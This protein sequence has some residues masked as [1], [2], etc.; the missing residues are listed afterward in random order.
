[1]ATVTADTR[2]TNSALRVDPRWPESV[3]SRSKSVAGLLLAVALV[4]ALAG[5]GGSSSAAGQSSAQTAS[6]ASSG[7]CADVTALKA[8]LAALTQVRPLKDGVPALQSAIGNVKTSLD[9]AAASASSTLQP[10]V[11]QVKSAFAAVQ[12]SV[13][14]LSCRQ[15]HAEGALHSRGA[16]PATHRSVR[17]C[18]DAHPEL[19]RELGPSKPWESEAQPVHPLRGPSE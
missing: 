4:C 9:T 7:G 18:H 19:P 6:S 12:T 3:S 5:C 2:A 16:D 10:Q 17:A 15:P 8:S 1:M 13:S 11:A 14:G